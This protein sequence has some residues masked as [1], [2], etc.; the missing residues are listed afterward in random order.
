MAETKDFITTTLCGRRVAGRAVEAGKAD[1]PLQLTAAEAEY[2][3]GQG[4][5][6]PKDKKLAD[7]FGG[8]SKKISELHAGIAAE[9]ARYAAVRAGRPS[10]ATVADEPAAAEAAVPAPPPAAPA[11]GAKAAATVKAD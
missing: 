6:V 1:Q 8:E 9:E 3:L 11:G 4:T 10:A 7:A 2:E 5:I